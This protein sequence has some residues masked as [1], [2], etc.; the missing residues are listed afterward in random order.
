MMLTYIGLI[1]LSFA[2]GYFTKWYTSAETKN[3][4]QDDNLDGSI[5]LGG[6][7]PYS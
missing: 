4:T 7:K 3:F 1:I 6:W 2:A 5:P